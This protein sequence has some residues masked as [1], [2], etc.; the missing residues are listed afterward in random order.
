M[1]RWTRFVLRHRRV[2]V[3]FWVAVIV[4]GGFASTRLP[5][6]LSN[7]FTVPGT[8]SEQARQILDRRFGDRPDGSFTFVFE[9]ADV[10]PAAFQA[11]LQ[12]AVDQAARAV[13]GGRATAL[14]TAGPHVAYGV[15]VST[16]NLAQA[17]RAT[18]AVRSARSSRRA[19]STPM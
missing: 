1:A 7:S 9:A 5:A 16:L 3:A 8:A 4:A 15:V 12:E 19:S 11:R 10:R 14:L 18:Q 6:L 13:P 2:V 17:K